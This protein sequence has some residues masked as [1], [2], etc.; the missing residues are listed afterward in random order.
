MSLKY[1]PF[2]LLSRDQENSSPIFSNSIGVSFGL[3]INQAF[4]FKTGLLLSVKGFRIH[5]NW[6]IDTLHLDSYS[7][8]EF[9]YLGVPITLR[10]KTNKEQKINY[11]I[12]SGIIYNVYLNSKEIQTGT[13]FFGNK[14][15][16]KVYT[17]R[18]EWFNYIN[19]SYLAQAGISLVVNE[20]LVF[21]PT[22]FTELMLNN[23]LND[24]EFEGSNK[25]YLHTIGLKLEVMYDF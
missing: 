22:I 17:S 20:K 21:N 25:L 18:R 7:K 5:D 15:D 14:I 6:K 1:D 16:R 12:E 8:N 11:T 23:Y 2:G 9:R 19:F 3:D 24:K 13:D 4:T 10:F